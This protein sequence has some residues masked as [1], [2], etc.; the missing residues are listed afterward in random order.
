MVPRFLD[1]IHIKGED[2]KVFHLVQEVHIDA[3]VAQC[4]TEKT[5]PLDQDYVLVKFC[6]IDMII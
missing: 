3:E 6:N 2:A 4:L 5:T 1:Y